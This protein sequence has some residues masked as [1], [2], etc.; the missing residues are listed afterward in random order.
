MTASWEILDPRL[1]P[2]PGVELL[3][4]AHCPLWRWMVW[5]TRSHL[6]AVDTWNPDRVWVA[7]LPLCEGSRVAVAVGHTGEWALLECPRWM[8]WEEAL[9]KIPV[10]RGRVGRSDP[11]TKEVSPAS[12]WATRF[13]FGPRLSFL[14][15]GCDLGSAVLWKIRRVQLT[16]GF[17]CSL[18]LVLR[19]PKYET[20]GFPAGVLN[21]HPTLRQVC[22]WARQAYP[23]SKNVGASYFLGVGCGRVDTASEGPEDQVVQPGLFSWTRLGGYVIWNLGWVTRMPHGSVRRGFPARAHIGCYPTPHETS[24]GSKIGA[25][26][27][28]RGGL[29]FFDRG[30]LLVEHFR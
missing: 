10:L 3:A 6:L 7:S 13:C 27:S 19:G 5:V 23:S 25:V 22:L 15:P 28:S 4:H 30:R 8:E 14:I 29:W 17:D 18:P 11:E 21:V 12:A 20:L 16:G 24:R 9:A 1:E 2:Q 26:E